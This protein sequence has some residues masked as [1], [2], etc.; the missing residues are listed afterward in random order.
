MNTEQFSY[1]F[2]FV[3]FKSQGI[4]LVVWNMFI[5]FSFHLMIGTHS[6]LHNWIVSILFFLIYYSI[7]IEQQ[8]TIWTRNNFPTCM[9]LIFLSTKG[10][11]L[12]SWVTQNNMFP[13]QFCKFC[14]IKSKCHHPTPMEIGCLWV[15]CNVFILFFLIYYSISIE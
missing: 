4:W 3:L 11:D 9:F 6:Y 1:L 8:K 5:L 12:K 15:V 7:S 10:F 14:S 13:N 2:V